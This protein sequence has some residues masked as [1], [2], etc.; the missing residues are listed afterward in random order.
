M[1]PIKTNSFTE[2]NRSPM[3]QFKLTSKKCECRRN[4]RT[5]MKYRTPMNLEILRE[6]RTIYRNLSKKQR[7]IT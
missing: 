7:L 3:V 6:I 1:P 5:Y 4:N 2:H